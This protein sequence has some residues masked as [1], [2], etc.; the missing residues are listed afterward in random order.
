MDPESRDIISAFHDLYYNGLAGEGR[1]YE[2]TKWMGVACLKCPLDM[3]A[4]QEILHEVRPDL[5][6]ETG[7]HMGGSALFMAHILDLL[8]KGEIITIDT[9]TAV[10]PSHPRIRYVLGSSADET[11][12]GDLLRGRSDEVRLVVLDSDHSED[13]VHRE[14]E[15]FSPFVTVGSYL[16]VEDTNINGHP[17]LPSHG[18]GPFEAVT[19]FLKSHPD[20]VVDETR[21]KFLMTF[22]PRGFLKR[23]R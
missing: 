15:L 12:V 6:I 8:G 5:V 23:I 1:I 3:W 11:L 16:I 4:Y 19:T 20:F 22:N 9:Q 2:R 21:E 10:R 14:L 7:T 13:H 17:T 18:P